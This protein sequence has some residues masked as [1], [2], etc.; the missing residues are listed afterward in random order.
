MLDALLGDFKTKF[1]VVELDHFS[2]SE[3]LL[4]INLL[5]AASVEAKE[6]HGEDDSILHVAFD[7]EFD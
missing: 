2:C 3:L 4:V 1:F 7:L 6:T 5:L